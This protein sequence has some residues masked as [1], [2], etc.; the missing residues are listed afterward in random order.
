MVD[1]KRNSPD[2]RRYDP[3]DE[4]VVEAQRMCTATKLQLQCP[5]MQARPAL[6]CYGSDA[7]QLGGNATLLLCCQ[8]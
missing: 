3:S 4:A 6:P 1:G 5:S 8:N 7:A 2:D